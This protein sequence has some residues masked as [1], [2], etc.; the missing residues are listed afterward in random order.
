MPCPLIRAAAGWSLV[1]PTNPSRCGRRMRMPPKQSTRSI[2]GLLTGGMQDATDPHRPAGILTASD[3]RLCMSLIIAVQQVSFEFKPQGSSWRMRTY[4]H[5]PAKNLYVW[6]THFGLLQHCTGSVSC[7]V[8]KCM[9]CIG[10]AIACTLM[11]RALQ[12]V[13][14]NSASLSQQSIRQSIRPMSVQGAPQPSV[15]FRVKAVGWKPNLT[16]LFAVPA[17]S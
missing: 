6:N 4:H 14:P 7:E 10:Q 8:L 2:S 9:H 1:R 13:M 12:S 3:F 15:G 17:H 5:N 16:C 11:C